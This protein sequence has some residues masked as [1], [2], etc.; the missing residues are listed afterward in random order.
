MSMLC[1]CYVSIQFFIRNMYIT[2][3]CVF[4]YI[5]THIYINMHSEYIY[6]HTY[7]CTYISYLS[8]I[9]LSLTEKKD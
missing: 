5:H 4:S 6:T 9:Y 3:S 7:V 8:Y 2:H 1:V